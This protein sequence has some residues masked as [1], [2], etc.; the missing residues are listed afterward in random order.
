MELFSWL[1]LLQTKNKIKKETLVVKTIHCWSVSMNPS[2]PS[3]YCLNIITAV[4][5]RI[6]FALNDI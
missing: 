3:S 6:A 5:S 1:K 4:S 2:N